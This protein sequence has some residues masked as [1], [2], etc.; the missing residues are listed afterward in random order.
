MA[1]YRPY[2]SSLTRVAPVF[3]NLLQRDRSGTSWIPQLLRLPRHGAAQVGEHVRVGNVLRHGW[4]RDEESLAPPLALLQWLVRNISDPRE[5]GAWGDGATLVK[6]KALRAGEEDVVNQALRQLESEPQRQAWYVL[7]G[8]SRPD[9]YL[10]SDQV[11][12]VIEG[13]RTEPGPTTHTTWMP[14]RHQM[15][16]H[17]DAV[18]ERRGGRPVYGFFIV[19]GD[20]AG[21]VP[22]AWINHAK[23]TVSPDV[24]EKSLPHR[25]NP[26]RADTAKAFLGVT[27]WQA[28]C[29][30]FGIE[31]ASL[32]DRLSDA[33]H[34]S[35]AVPE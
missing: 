12:I 9:V 4:G 33:S 25:T 5:D 30:A 24:L 1:Q 29:G 16:R 10:E 7:E 22:E 31:W 19:E 35:Q 20:G 32:P 28:V 18:W 34:V 27:T 3:D 23:L 21:E 17:I 14:V 11:L 13:K 26:E 15:L 6:R 8:A 2:D